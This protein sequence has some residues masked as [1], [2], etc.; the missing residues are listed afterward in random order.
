[1]PSIGDPINPITLN[2]LNRELT[3]WGRP[4]VEGMGASLPYDVEL[5][6]LNTSHR[7]PPYQLRH[8]FDSNSVHG[9][10]VDADQLI[11]WHESSRGGR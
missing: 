8:L 1:M 11:A 5:E 4:Q 3:G 6:G 9:P 2:Q 10:L 7:H